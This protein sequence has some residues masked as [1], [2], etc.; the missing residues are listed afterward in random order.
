MTDYTN[1]NGVKWIES[2]TFGAPENSVMDGPTTAIFMNTFTSVTPYTNNV[3]QTLDLSNHIPVG[4]KHVLMGGLFAITNGA[5]ETAN[6]TVAFRKPGCSTDFTYNTEAISGP[7][8]NEPDRSSLTMIAPVDSNRCTE[9]KPH[10]FTTSGSAAAGISYLI[11]ANVIGYWRGDAADQPP[12]EV[13]AAW[14]TVCSATMGLNGSGMQN[15]TVV[16]QINGPFSNGGS[17]V[18]ITVHPNGSLY[19]NTLINKCYVGKKAGSGDPYDFDGGQV[20]VTFAGSAG[21]TLTQGG[22]GVTS[23][24]A[25]IALVSS[26]NIL[27]SCELGNA[28]AMGAGASTAITSYYKTS[29][30]DSA[31]TNKTGY[32]TVSGYSYLVGKLQFYE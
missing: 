4:T 7:L 13:S 20:Q 19:G 29:A 16:T 25:T 17:K 22:A 3:W 11:N 14:H 6:I 8:A 31:T 24:E 23:D 18:R 9:F 2:S 10:W 30:A 5:I 12:A 1:K 28:P 21:V 27:V 26:D 15:A 32:T